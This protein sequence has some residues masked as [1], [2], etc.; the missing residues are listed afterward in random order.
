MNKNRTKSLY[1]NT[2]K[3]TLASSLFLLS[4]AA[5]ARELG[6]LNGAV[7]WLVTTLISIALAVLG[8][9]IMYSLWQVNQGHKEWR[10]VAKPILITAAIVS[11]PTIVT[12]LAATM[13]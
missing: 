13:K 6:A 11:V 10:E 7:D 2:Q 8:L 4:R 9:Q 1:Q 5:C 3:A 12:V